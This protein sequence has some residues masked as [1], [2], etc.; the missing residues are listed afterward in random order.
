MI[1]CTVSAVGCETFKDNSSLIVLNQ[2]KQCEYKSECLGKKE[3]N[4]GRN[5][6]KCSLLL[7]PA[8]YFH[9]NGWQP[10]LAKTESFD[11]VISGNKSL[12]NVFNLYLLPYLDI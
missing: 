10:L 4:V 3:I 5:V 9:K 7:N 2:T 11:F 1:F 6:T 8:Q 12:L